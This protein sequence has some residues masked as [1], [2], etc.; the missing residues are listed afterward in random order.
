MSGRELESSLR[1]HREGLG[2]SQQRVGDLVGVSRQAIAAI[3]A[4][5]QVPSTR[6]S[7]QLA[8]AL[9]C[10]V[11]DLFSLPEP[12][13]LPA[14]VAPPGPSRHRPLTA[15]AVA[16]V[17]VA[18]ISGHWVAHPLPP[19]P[20]LA[21]DGLLQRPTTGHGAIVRPLVD[22]K[23]LRHNVILAGCA[24]VLGSLVRHVNRLS[25][26]GR[27]T[28]L[29]T[30]SEQSLDLLTQ[31]LVHFAGIHFPDAAGVNG[32][33]EAVR[34]R[35]PGQAM[36]LVNVTRWRQGF[37]LPPGRGSAF[38]AG[39]GWLGPDV[40]V[41]RR[42]E[43]A[44]AHRLLAAQLQQEGRAAAGLQGPAA[45][46]HAEVAQ[47]VQCGAADLGISIEGEAL[48][49]GLDF[50]PLSEERFDLV[51]PAHLA[52]TE[53]VS[54]VL[55]VLGDSSFRSELAHVPGYDRALTGSV[56]VVEAA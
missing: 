39:G 40:R 22:P 14:R 26:A 30:N 34:Q 4:G 25:V 28:W 21:A 10:R 1:G 13:G 53:H 16:R 29:P 2:L 19:D 5:R 42:E 35:F 7:L 50:V 18:E 47:L 24:P 11:E 51:V 33:V 41:A 43:G 23:R 48:A 6:L 55:Q 3:E 20:T 49:S 31:G 45:F 36:L 12:E 15:G 17:T 44:A 54:R 56:T 8:R 52:D 27:A 37:V 9:R 38:K 46:G 32:H